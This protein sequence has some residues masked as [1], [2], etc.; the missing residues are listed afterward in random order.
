MAISSVSALAES[1][2]FSLL[3]LFDNVV[4]PGKTFSRAS[5]RSLQ[6]SGL[7]AR[8]TLSGVLGS[9]SCEA[10]QYPC[11]LTT[12]WNRT[13]YLL[14][15]LPVVLEPELLPVLVM[16]MLASVCAHSILP[17]TS[18]RVMQNNAK[19]DLKDFC[20]LTEINYF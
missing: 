15:L 19:Y 6:W 14:S 2:E 3:R 13:S 20:D 4:T 12:L 10:L 8:L 1:D 18:Y 16:P 17:L 7:S 9:R 5:D 11:L